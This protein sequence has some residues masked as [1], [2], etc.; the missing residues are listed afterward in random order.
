VS[1][2]H[3]HQE[4]YPG[5]CGECRRQAATM[6]AIEVSLTTGIRERHQ[7]R[8]GTSPPPHRSP[9]PAWPDALVADAGGHHSVDGMLDSI[10]GRVDGLM[11]A[12]AAA[13]E[14]HG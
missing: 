7:G 11:V 5:G 9:P 14:R 12:L 2:S 6:P 1:G 3:L 4:E 10:V 8:G 13:E